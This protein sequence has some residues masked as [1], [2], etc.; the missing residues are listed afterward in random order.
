MADNQAINNKRGRSPR[1]VRRK[2]YLNNQNKKNQK[3]KTQFL[4]SIPLPTSNKFSVL[5]DS[6][7]AM[8]TSEQQQQQQI[9]KKKPFH[10]SSLPIIKQTFKKFSKI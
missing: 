1:I 10:Q 6:G 4:N 3:N 2:I 9:P 8:D 7:N 5:G